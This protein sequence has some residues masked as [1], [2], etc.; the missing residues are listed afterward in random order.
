MFIITQ[1][2][3]MPQEHCFPKYIWFWALN[4][5]SFSNVTSVLNPLLLDHDY[6]DSIR[7]IQLFGTISTINTTSKYLACLELII[8]TQKQRTCVTIMYNRLG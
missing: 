8:F 7:Q 4:S 6:Q 2:E 1:S 5:K 3:N